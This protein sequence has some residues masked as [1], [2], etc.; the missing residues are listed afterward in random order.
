MG[1]V[2]S[3][4]VS[5]TTSTGSQTSNSPRCGTDR[6]SNSSSC[7]TASAHY[8]PRGT[9]STMPNSSPAMSQGST[10][11]IKP[12]RT[13]SPVD[14]PPNGC[15]RRDKPIDANPCS[16]IGGINS[17]FRS[18]KVLTPFSDI[19]LTDTTTPLSQQRAERKPKLF[20]FSCAA[21]PKN[22][23]KNTSSAPTESKLEIVRSRL[24]LYLHPTPSASNL[25]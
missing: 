13:Y 10:Q 14:R 2:M 25:I 17:L 3:R 19:P 8:R 7:S 23:E 1:C 24:T 6:Y 12:E 11:L 21:K 4:K 22:Q 20:P 16:V 5:K 15:P 9:E 18:K